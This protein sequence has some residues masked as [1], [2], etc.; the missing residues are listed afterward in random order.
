[1]FDL[2]MLRENSKENSI[3]KQFAPKELKGKKIHSTGKKIFF[4]FLHLLKIGVDWSSKG[5]IAVNY[6]GEDV[7][8]FHENSSP[9]EGS[10]EVVDFLQVYRGR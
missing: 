5:E 2:R 1:M 10:N 6:S 9:V 4:F 3:V 8:L 7:Y